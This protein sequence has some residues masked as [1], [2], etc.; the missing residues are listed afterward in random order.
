MKNRILICN[1]TSGIS[2]GAEKVTDLFKE[3]LKRHNLQDDYDVI[4][5]GD[6][7]LFRDVLVDIVAPD[8]E[9]ITYEYVTPDDVSKIVEEHL[10]KGEPVEK[11]WPVRITGSSSPARPASF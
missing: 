10:V 2:A 3:G 8:K 5:T 9:R 11:S 4:K 1:G 6:R 7:G